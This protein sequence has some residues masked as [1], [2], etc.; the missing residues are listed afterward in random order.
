MWFA[1]VTVVE[2]LYFF[3]F[4][5][6]GNS[7]ICTASL[8]VHLCEFVDGRCVFVCITPTQLPTSVCP[9]YM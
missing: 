4:N 6:L 2:L 8:T 7:D 3:F 1:N 5:R 9:H